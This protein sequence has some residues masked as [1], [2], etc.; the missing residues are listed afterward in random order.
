MDSSALQDRCE[1]LEVEKAQAYECGELLSKLVQR[2]ATIVE[3]VDQELDTQLQAVDDQL[4]EFPP[5]SAFINRSRML[6]SSSLK[7]LQRREDV[8][9]GNVDALERLVKQL[10]GLAADPGP[11]QALE[12][13]RTEINEQ[14]DY[15]YNYPQLLST[16]SRL[17]GQVLRDF[18]ASSESNFDKVADSEEQQLLCRHIGGLLLKLLE[19]LSVP[20][21]LQPRA[22]KL[23]KAI[24]EGFGWN[25]LE[26][27]LQET[28]DLAVKVTITGHQD[29]ETYLKSL[30]SQLGGIQSFLSESRQYQQQARESTEKLDKTLRNDV[31]QVE[32]AL[33]QSD[34]LDQLKSS[35]RSQLS[36]I[37]SA[38]DL[39]R[40]EQVEREARA[41]QRLQELNARI[42]EME[43][44]SADVQR[45]LEEQKLLAVLDPLTGL[46][47]RAAYDDKMKQLLVE[48]A[49]KHQSLTLV[50]GDIDRFKQVNDQFGHLAGD[51]VLRLVA[52]I[53]R[54]GLRESDFICRYGG[55]EFVVVMQATKASQAKE[56]MDK[57][58]RVL[59]QSPFNFKGEPVEVTSS[60]GI[61]EYSA[62]ESADDLFSRADK[63]LYQA[64]ETGRNC[65]QIAG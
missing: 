9:R 27:L 49:D 58:R 46:P 64:K 22:R 62:G 13:L 35:V 47:N 2:L 60:F 28:V 56:L 4:K 12:K 20:S 38:V 14:T 50:V 11:Q 15:F 5:E 37:V 19:R 44:K 23:L 34:N 59:Q 41:E 55:E 21:E 6:I 63:A 1:L 52:K 39:Y 43:R 8:V 36:G 7:V 53:L 48:E 31:A 54:G 3:G 29:F 30:N 61:A 40:E 10:A 24:E 25:E 18:A 65:C 57:L 45:K 17:Q 51:K 32:V 26:G 42:D 16:L 33:N